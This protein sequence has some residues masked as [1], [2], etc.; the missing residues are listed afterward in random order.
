MNHVHRLSS[1]ANKEPELFV[2]NTPTEDTSLG[3]TRQ[4]YK[5]SIRA[6]YVTNVRV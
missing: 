4:R 6:M 5:I 1:K 3:T 2:S